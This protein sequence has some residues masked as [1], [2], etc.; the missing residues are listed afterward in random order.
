MLT[1][2]QVNVF[3]PATSKAGNSEVY[4]VALDY[5]AGLPLDRFMT[6][7]GVWTTLSC[8]QCLFRQ[9]CNIPVTM[10]AVRFTM[11]VILT[12]YFIITSDIFHC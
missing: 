1:V 4:V 6:F 12:Y 11:N 2:S 5:Q 7:L 10:Y 8:C 9:E 3:K